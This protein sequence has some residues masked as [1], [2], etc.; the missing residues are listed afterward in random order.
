MTEDEVL[1]GIQKDH[2]LKALQRIDEEG[3]PKKRLSSDYDLIYNGIAYPP[4][5]VIS[6]AGFFKDSQFI[7][8]RWFKGGQNSK[9]FSILRNYGFDVLPKTETEQFKKALVVDQRIHDKYNKASSAFDSGISYSQSDKQKLD[10]LIRKLSDPQLFQQWVEH[11]HKSIAERGIA[12]DFIR[13]AIAPGGKLRVECGARLMWQ[14]QPKGDTAKICFYVPKTIQD[15]YLD[16]VSSPYD[17]G[18]WSSEELMSFPEFEVK[19]W[20]EIPQE[21]IE[22]NQEAVG[23]HYASEENSNRHNIR[24]G[25]GTTNDAL[26]YLLFENVPVQEWLKMEA[27]SNTDNA[28][29][30]SPNTTIMP[31]NQ[32]LYGPPGTG[33]TYSTKAYAVSLG[34]NGDTSDQ[35]RLNDWEYRDECLQKFEELKSEG[36]EEFVTFHQ[37]FAY[38]DFVQGIRPN[39]KSKEL[40]FVKKD[41]IFKTIC[42]NALFEYYKLYWQSEAKSKSRTFDELWADFTARVSKDEGTAYQMQTKSGTT[43]LVS[44]VSDF[45]NLIITHEGA[46]R[47]Y[48]VSMPRMKKIYDE[49]DSVEDIKNIVED[50][51]RVIGGSNA[52]AYWAVFNELKKFEEEDVPAEAIDQQ[53]L[54]SLEYEE[55]LKRTKNLADL[56]PFTKEKVPQYVLIIDEINRAN[57]SRVLGELITLL[58]P[59][60]R[61]GAKD[62]LIIKLP[63]GEDFAVP[64]NL[65]I[66]GTMNTADKSIAHLDVALR[67]RFQ[68]V[69]VYPDSSLV[70]DPRKKAVLEELN[71]AIVAE[72]NPDL[73]IGHSYF[74]NGES[75]EEIMDQKV[76][77]LLMEYFSHQSDQVAKI[78]SSAGVATEEN[79][80]GLLT[81]NGYQADEQE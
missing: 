19:S 25:S 31:H 3:Y 7:K 62:E 15:K 49:F 36:R 14:F 18:Q 70:T 5:Y 66:I 71:K 44:S 40:S 43:V 53:D 30:V 61:L 68:F 58:E 38:E 74:M 41:G 52:S 69:P 35:A 73:T 79:G 6:L 67:R 46:S 56:A 21:V 37:S 80:F 76:I 27:P 32:I 48:T 45:G 63:S 20:A 47:V 2:I 64:P 77:P 29:T 60:K 10:K 81:C 24:K 16:Q 23:K 28:E 12:P 8:H 59:D 34:E 51:R 4:S 11:C 55:R 78:L 54:D 26:K 75:L 57:I 39:V 33:K 22:V 13:M 9:A 50:T 65:H 17:Y 42:T 1:S 72:G